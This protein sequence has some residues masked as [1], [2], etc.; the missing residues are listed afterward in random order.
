MSETKRIYTDGIFDLFH[1]GHARCLEQIK[2]MY[3][4]TTLIVGISNDSDTKLYK[5]LPVMTEKERYESVRHC[6]WVDEII[7]DAPWTITPEFIKLHNIDYVAHDALPYIDNS[8]SSEDGDCY[9]WLKKEGLFKETERTSEISTSELITRITKNYNDYVIRNLSRGYDRYDMGISLLKEKR[10]LL[11]YKLY[12]VSKR[13]WDKSKSFY[14]SDFYESVIKR[15][16][17][18]LIDFVNTE[19]NEM[20]Y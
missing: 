1:Y 17:D 11:K 2:Q 5:G 13:V 20:F 10:I 9:G 3:P 7:E 19:R 18:T 6:K 15:I 16:M 4:N 8:G 12:N 14:E